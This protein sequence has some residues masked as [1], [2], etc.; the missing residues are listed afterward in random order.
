MWRKIRELV[1]SLGKQLPLSP[2]DGAEVAVKEV[3]KKIFGRLWK[4]AAALCGLLGVGIAVKEQLF[5]RFE[6]AAQQFLEHPVLGGATIVI[7]VAYAVGGA[8]FAWIAK[9]N[10]QM[11]AAL[12]SAKRFRELGFV[13]A[14][15]NLPAAPDEKNEQPWVDIRAAILHDGNRS[16]RLLG[17]N[18]DETFGGIRS[19]LYQT[20]DKFKY[21]IQVILIDPSCDDMLTR[22]KDLGMDRDQYR[23]AI[24]TSVGRLNVVGGHTQVDWRFYDR[25]PVWKFIITDHSA[26]VSY[27]PPKKHVHETTVF[28][29][30]KTNDE[31]DIYR[32]IDTEFNRIWERRSV[33]HN[34][35]IEQLRK[36]CR[37]ADARR[38]K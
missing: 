33:R 6:N 30:D 5:V 8:Y 3:W 21:P 1:K 34:S 26:W 18:G 28:R 15:K 19:G 7:V 24:F 35:T 14:W 22:T 23:Q 29:F 25:Y 37:D 13:N 4:L 20:L 32:L 16:L 27:Y 31:N 38:S 2:V 17:A 12:T 11:G 9:R 10:V 36:A